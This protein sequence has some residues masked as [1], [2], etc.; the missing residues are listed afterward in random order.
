MMLSLIVEVADA[1]SNPPQRRLHP[2]SSLQARRQTSPWSKSH[3]SQNLD[4]QVSKSAFFVSSCCVQSVELPMF[5][6]HQKALWVA[7]LLLILEQQS[8]ILSS[9]SYN[10]AR[11]ST[12][13]PFLIPCFPFSV[14]VRR[15]RNLPRMAN[16]L[17][18]LRI[19]PEGVHETVLNYL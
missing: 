15:R 11:S 12:A 10:Y 4:V 9:S 3:H 8:T 1:D 2:A 19:R 18:V 13:F 14:N 6:L 17:D 5:K 7:D 16:S